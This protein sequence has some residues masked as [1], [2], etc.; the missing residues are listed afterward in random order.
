MVYPIP[1]PRTLGK[2][3]KEGQTLAKNLGSGKYSP[4]C[5]LAVA[6]TT[7]SFLRWLSTHQHF[8][9]QGQ[10]LPARS[11]MESIKAGILP[12][13]IPYCAPIL[14]ISP[15]VCEVYYLWL[16]LLLKKPHLGWASWQAR[17]LQLQLA[18][19]KALSTFHSWA[20][21]FRSSQVGTILYSCRMLEVGKRGG[22]PAEIISV[23][24]EHP[25]IFHWGY[26][27]MAMTMAPPSW[28]IT[29][30]YYYY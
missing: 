4:Y 27:T 5:Q 22:T 11:H 14:L 24:I 12:P 25:P 20:T 16:A 17:H 29:S 3:Q 19:T 26:S 28:E 15:H 7:Y 10:W 18:L 21:G 23:A 30:Y 8:W 13:K 1:R 9:L 6:W 2:H